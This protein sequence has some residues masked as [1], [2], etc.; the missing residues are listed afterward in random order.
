MENDHIF[1]FAILTMVLSLG[2]EALL[3]CT[4]GGNY[5]GLSLA[6][7]AFLSLCIVRDSEKHT[8]FRW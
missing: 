8:R 6:L 3:F 4:Y 7:G 5:V 1:V 2:T